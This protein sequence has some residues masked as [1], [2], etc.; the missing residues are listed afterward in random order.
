MGTMTMRARLAILVALIA[1]V[2][3]APGQLAGAIVKQKLVL[4]G[5]SLSRETQPTVAAA[6]KT[7]ANYTISIH[8]EIGKAPCD[9]IPGIKKAFGPNRN[10]VVTHYELLV[11]ETAGNSQSACMD[12]PGQ[13]ARCYMPIG[14]PEWEAKYRT[15]LDTI[16]AL[17]N[18]VNTPVLFIT[19]PP[20]AGI[21]ANRNDV[22]N[23]VEPEVL[24]DNPG[25][26]S[27]DAP[28]ASV[29]NP[30]GS[31][32]ATLPC[33]PSETAADGCVDGSIPVRAPDGLHFCPTG[34]Q[35]ACPE[36]SSGAFRFGTAEA[37]VINADG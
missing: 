36:Y 4:F 32:A 13:C 5:D 34:F 7:N 9:F 10:G 25:V 11:I 23:T 2:G 31:F 26:V 15:D 16:V 17:A 35:V 1:V 24:A 14:S 27:S 21:A 29:S 28:R 37:T 20:M 18:S 3:I 8:G 33:L 12:E 30:D 22:Y 19:P 6:F